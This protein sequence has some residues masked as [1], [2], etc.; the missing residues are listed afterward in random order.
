MLAMI[1]NLFNGDGI[2]ILSVMMLLLGAKNAPAAA[3]W[4]AH[5]REENFLSI[6]I[7]IAFLLMLI[8]FTAVYVL[9]TH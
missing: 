5:A 2:I 4:F 3:N 1:S 6:N 9:K 8:L 7:V